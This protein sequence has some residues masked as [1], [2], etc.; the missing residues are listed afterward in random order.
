MD[1]QAREVQLALTT[2]LATCASIGLDID[3]IFHLAADELLSGDLSGDEQP[4]APAAV[5]WL[6]MALGEVG[7]TF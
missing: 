3:Q 5:I 2:I 4:L 1:N 7:D 6:G